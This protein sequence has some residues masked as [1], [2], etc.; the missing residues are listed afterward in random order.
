MYLFMDDFVY[1]SDDEIDS[2]FWIDLNIEKDLEESD[3][4]V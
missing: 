4:N 1:D 2:D 3:H